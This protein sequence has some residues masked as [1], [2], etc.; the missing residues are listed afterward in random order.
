[1]PTDLGSSGRCNEDPP[2]SGGLHSST[3]SSL[4]GR[5]GAASP[6]GGRAVT[7][8]ESFVSS[9][10]PVLGGSY[11]YPGGLLSRGL[12]GDNGGGT[13]IVGAQSLGN[14]GGYGVMAG[15]QEQVISPVSQGG[16]EGKDFFATPISA[17]RGGRPTSLDNDPLRSLLQALTIAMVRPPLTEVVGMGTRRRTGLLQQALESMGG[18]RVGNP[19][20]MEDKGFDRERT[21]QEEAQASRDRPEGPANV[22]LFRYDPNGPLICG[23]LISSKKGPK[24]F[25]ISTVCGLAHTKKAFDKLGEGDYYIVEPS[26]RGGI[27]SQASRALLE[28]LLPKAAAE[29]SAEKK[30]VL[31]AT[32]SMERWLSLFRYL[33][34]AAARGDSPGSNLEL[35]GFATRAWQ[36]AFKTPLQGNASKRS[37]YGDDEEEAEYG[38]APP[39]VLGL[40]DAIM[41]IQVEL[42]IRS[43]KATYVTLHTG[44][45]GVAEELMVVEERMEAMLENTQNKIGSLRFKT[46]HASVTS[47]EVKRWMEQTQSTGQGT[48]QVNRLETAIGTLQN[49]CIFLEDA[50]TQLASFVT[51]LKDKVDFG[52]GSGTTAAGSLPALLPAPSWQ[53]IWQR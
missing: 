17:R 38:D 12:S 26:G 7:R 5:F 21:R 53:R 37:S 22:R 15:Y 33:I 48:S 11:V 16:E 1:M 31:E 28:P 49:R 19:K 44:V 18:A 42:G 34:E 13:T 30:E 23:G 20:A 4:Q 27:S 39:I 41:G 52:G 51:S 2:P 50:F 6:V 35:A 9:V 8:G 32:N 40:Q 10:L 25:C 46:T 24:Q 29:Y 45:K 3:L 36:S 47:M 14:S 43:P